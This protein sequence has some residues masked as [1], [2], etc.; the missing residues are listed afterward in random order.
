MTRHA[1]PVMWDGHPILWGDWGPVDG[2]TFCGGLSK[3]GWR[4]CRQCHTRALPRM[5]SGQVCDHSPHSLVLFRCM[6]CGHTTVMELTDIDGNECWREWTL[7]E[8]DYEDE[9]SVYCQQ[10]G[11]FL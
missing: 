1:L 4:G 3:K 11:L 5:I 10:G 7:D 2:I 6:T 9:G 8:S